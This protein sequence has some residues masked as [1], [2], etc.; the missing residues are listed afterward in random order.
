[1]T[2]P[3]Q[4]TPQEKDKALIEAQ[5]RLFACLEETLKVDSSILQKERTHTHPPAFTVVQWRLILTENSITSKMCK[6]LFLKDKKAMEDTVVDLKV[7]TK[8]L[9]LP[10][11]CLRFAPDEQLRSVQLLSTQL[12]ISAV[13][14]LALIQDREHRVLVLVDERI[15][16]ENGEEMLCF[17]PLSNRYTMLLT[18][19]EMKRFLILY[20]VQWI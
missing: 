4:P 18:G 16:E 20:R 11:G 13:S 3:P 9:K 7:V 14:P 15:F 5:Q 6:N 12:R 19:S 8:M 17:H 10:S 2:D 1:M